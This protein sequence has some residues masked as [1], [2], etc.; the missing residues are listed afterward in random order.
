ENAPSCYAYTFFCLFIEK[1]D[2]YCRCSN[3][4]VRNGL[5]RSMLTRTSC[6]PRYHSATF[7]HPLKCTA[8]GSLI[9]GWSLPNTSI[10]ELSSAAMS[11]SMYRSP[12]SRAGS[13][14]S[15]CAM[16]S[17]RPYGTICSSTAPVG[18]NTQ[19]VSPAPCTPTITSYEFT[20]RA[21]SS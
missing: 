12:M 13:P 11:Y 9:M 7:P 2:R 14:K 17:S 3:A 15:V 20:S 5:N 1:K 8:T 16:L 19:L 18:R 10:S 4:C 21:N 6:F